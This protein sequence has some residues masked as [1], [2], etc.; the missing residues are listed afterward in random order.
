MAHVDGGGRFA[1]FVLEMTSES[2][3]GR[4]KGPKKDL[5]ARLGVRE[6]WQFDPEGEY[7]SPRLRGHRLAPDGRYQALEL[8]ERDGYL[9]HES[10][11]GLELRLEGARLRFFDPARG[12]YLL[13]NLEKEDA[14]REKEEA[15]RAKDA[16][17]RAV[18]AENAMLK[19]RLD[20]G[21]D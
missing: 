6:Y 16:A 1:D 8:E 14:L 17:L 18:Q 9:C 21:K 20:R 13:T 2:S 19:R 4:D 10:L 11:L 15:L 12:G 7:L 5:F 3:R